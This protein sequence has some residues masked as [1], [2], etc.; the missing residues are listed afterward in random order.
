MSDAFTCPG[1]PTAC[2]GLMTYP[3]M[4]CSQCDRVYYREDEAIDRV[5]LMCFERRDTAERQLAALRAMSAADPRA[6][7]DRD[8]EDKAAEARAF[9]RFA[10]DVLSGLVRK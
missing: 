6:V 3:H 4:T 8:I 5:R 7:D 9:E 10:E 1:C 2:A